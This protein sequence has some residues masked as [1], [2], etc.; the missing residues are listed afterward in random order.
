[1]A[2]SPWRTAVCSRRKE[3]TII[4][5]ESRSDS[6]TRTRPSAARMSLWRTFS[7]LRNRYPIREMATPA[8]TMAHTAARSMTSTALTALTSMT[9][10]PLA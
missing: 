3:R 2:A 8:G 1:M 10:M 5:S 6:V 4:S 7:F 9:S